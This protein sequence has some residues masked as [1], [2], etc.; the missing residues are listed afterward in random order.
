M[1]A[2]AMMAKPKVRRPH[3]FLQQLVSAEVE[4][5]AP[6]LPIVPVVQAYEEQIVWDQE[7]EGIGR[8][9]WFCGYFIP[10]DHPARAL[11]PVLDA[12]IVPLQTRYDLGVSCA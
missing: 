1:D 2:E 8:A 9:P 3:W 7:C 10:L 12:A 6:G 5:L 11:K 4:R